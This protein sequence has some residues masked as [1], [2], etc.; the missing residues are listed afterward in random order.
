MWDC[1]VDNEKLVSPG[2]YILLVT[3]FNDAGKVKKWKKV[4]TVIR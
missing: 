2:V 1:T 4:C 3:V